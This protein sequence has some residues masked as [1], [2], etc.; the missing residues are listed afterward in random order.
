M[1]WTQADHDHLKN[2]LD[3]IEIMA[4]V[5]IRE[6]DATKRRKLA[7]ELRAKLETIR[8]IQYDAQ[9]AAQYIAQRIAWLEQP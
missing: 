4:F 6:N 5:G 8:E 9:N 2:E 3:R 1:T 7:E